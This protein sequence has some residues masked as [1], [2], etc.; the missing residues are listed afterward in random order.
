LLCAVRREV[1]R[2][3]AG[4]SHAKDSGASAWRFAVPLPRFRAR[5][6]IVA[7]IHLGALWGILPITD[8]EKF[9]EDFSCITKPLGYSCWRDDENAFSNAKQNGRAKP[10][11]KGNYPM[12]TRCS[13]RHGQSKGNR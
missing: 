13:G 1:P 9:F 4:L 7:G 3:L 2:F 6:F 11:G 10:I 5:R 8:R 12:A